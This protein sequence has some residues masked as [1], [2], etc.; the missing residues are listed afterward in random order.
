MQLYCLYATKLGSITMKRIV[1]MENTYHKYKEIYFSFL[2]VVLTM[3]RIYNIFT[4]NNYH[5]KRQTITLIDDEYYYYY[6]CYTLCL[7]YVHTYRVFSLACHGCVGR[8]PTFLLILV[9][10]Y[11]RRIALN[12]SI[13]FPLS[14]R[15]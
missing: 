2:L 12:Y 11:R 13:R 10:V 6:Y 9:I 4:P 3:V 5:V 7:F 1:P 15:R 8:S 14:P